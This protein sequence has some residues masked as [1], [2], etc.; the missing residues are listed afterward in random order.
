L[1]KAVDA[2][3]RRS[4]VHIVNEPT[5]SVL[6]E[7]AYDEPANNFVNYHFVERGLILPQFGDERRVREALEEM[8]LGLCP[9]R[10]MRPVLVGGLPLAPRGV[11]ECSTQPVLAL[12][13]NQDWA[14][15]L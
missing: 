3:G 13:G 4:E 12:D 9:H 15:D 2:R 10:V 7:M 1:D 14:Q 11:I 5:Q 8:F 6:G